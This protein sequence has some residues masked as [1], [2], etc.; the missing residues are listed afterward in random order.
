VAVPDDDGAFR[1]ALLAWSQG[2]LRALPWRATRDPWAVLV[3]EVMLQQTQVTRV[4]PAYRRF[5]ASFPSAR[6]CA[7][8]PQGAVVAAWQGLGYNRRARNLHLI[9]QA[10]VACHSGEIPSNFDALCLLP[11]VG[12]YTARA[13]LAFA[14]ERDVA[15]IDVNAARVLARIAGRRLTRGEIQGRADHLVPEGKGWRWNQ[16]MLDLGATVC[17]R[18][19]PRCHACPLVAWCGWRRSGEPDPAASSVGAGRPQTPFR[20]SDRQGRG[21]L[22]RALLLA[23][24]SEEE[25]ATACGWPASPARARRVAEALVADGLATR[26]PRGLELA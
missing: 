1:Q 23:P 20:G 18:R 4:I 26:T 16:A 17:V 19:D 22:L 6:D 7:G 2:A 5:L 25:L 11:G 13:V 12:P 10:V 24:V 21:R 8:A 14:F 9:A 15:A 3:S